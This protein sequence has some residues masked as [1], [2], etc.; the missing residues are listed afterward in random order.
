MDVQQHQK[1]V[2]EIMNVIE[3]NVDRKSCFIVASGIEKSIGLSIVRPN[4]EIV[5]TV[6]Y[7]ES[8]LDRLEHLANDLLNKI[9]EIKS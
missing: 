4:K 1:A 7:E 9:K 6:I 2:H 8:K 5:C 3:W